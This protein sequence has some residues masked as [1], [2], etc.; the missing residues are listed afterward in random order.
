MSSPN[1]VSTNM[2]Y[3]TTVDTGQASPW[4]IETYG[5]L[6]ASSNTVLVANKVYM[7]AFELYANCT[8]TAMRW[9]TGSTA[10]GNTDMGIYDSSGNLLAHTGATANSANSNMSANIAKDGSGNTITSIALAP[11]KYLMA[12]CPSTSTDTYTRSS[13]INGTPILDNHCNATNTGTSG[14][15]PGTTGTITVS[16]SVIPHMAAV[17]SGGLA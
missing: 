12:L 17:V 4:I 1:T 6:G 8:I 15:L 7:W 11:G 10:A 5:V 9:G 16:A 13:F 14:V 3:P 2:G